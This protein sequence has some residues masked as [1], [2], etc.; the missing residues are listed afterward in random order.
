MLIEQFRDW[1]LR[2]CDESEFSRFSQEYLRGFVNM[3]DLVV[4]LM[5]QIYELQ[6]CVEGLIEDIEFNGSPQPTKKIT[7]KKGKKS[8]SK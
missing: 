8:E 6:C 3:Q 7:K 5:H 2:Q 4:S 1:S